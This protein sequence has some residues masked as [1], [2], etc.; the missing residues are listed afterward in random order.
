MWQLPLFLLFGGLALVA[1]VYAAFD[2]VRYARC[3]SNNDDHFPKSLV[4]SGTAR[5]AVMLLIISLVSLAWFKLVSLLAAI[6]SSPSLYYP[7]DLY[8]P[9]N[10]VQQSFALIILPRLFDL[11][12]LVLVAFMVWAL[13]KEGDF[14]K[15]LSVRSREKC[16]LSRW[17]VML[18]FGA[19]VYF[20]QWILSLP[21]RLVLEYIRMSNRSGIGVIALYIVL[22]NIGGLALIGLLWY[23]SK[24]DVRG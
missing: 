12:W 17:S 23:A 5:I 1:G 11:F 4:A 24:R 10:A 9:P 13:I 15:L 14:K 6:I 19:A 7:S 21:Q 20:V 16:V 18:L 2:V 22:A 3:R 8:L